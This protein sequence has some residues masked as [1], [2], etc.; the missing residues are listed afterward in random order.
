M[1]NKLNADIHILLGLIARFRENDGDEKLLALIIEQ[2]QVRQD[3]LNTTITNSTL[4]E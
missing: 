1:D 2:L 3:E 4:G